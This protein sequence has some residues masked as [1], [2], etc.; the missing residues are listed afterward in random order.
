MNIEQPINI[1]IRRRAAI[2]DVIMTTGVIRE[3]KHRYGPFSNIDIVTEKLG[4]WRNNPHIRNM[5]HVNEPPSVDN[6]DVYINLDNAYEAN[7]LNHFIDSMFYRAFG[8]TN[9]D[10]STELWPTDEDCDLVDQDIA[11]N[12]G[13]KFIIVHMR[14]WHYTQKNLT[15]DVWLEVFGKLFEQQA[16][17]RIVCVGGPTDHV[18]DHPLFVDRREAYT[19]QQLKHLSD[20]AACFVGIDSGPYWCASASSTHIVALLTNVPP[21]S[22]LPH[23]EGELGYNCTAITTRE[24]CA[25]CYN[26]QQRPVVA[27][28][29]KKTT[30][31]CNNNFNTDA[32]AEAILKQL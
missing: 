2:G 24:D 25:G 12:I 7:P 21:E 32:I 3:L 13:D 29:C 31:P 27:W 11:N 19:D 16:D 14:N 17:F 5:Y 6:Y 20:R 1:L 23:R 28:T 22:I 10:R 8:T 26:E 9:L 4:I 30:T 15:M 18:I